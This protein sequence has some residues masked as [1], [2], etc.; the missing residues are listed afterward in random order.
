[1]SE[2]QKASNALAALEEKKASL[3][4]EFK[5]T[6]DLDAEYYEDSDAIENG[7][8]C[9]E[10]DLEW[11]DARDLDYADSMVRYQQLLVRALTILAQGDKKSLHNANKAFETL[12]RDARRIKDDKMADIQK[13]QEVISFMDEIIQACDS[14]RK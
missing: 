9:G 14:H 11:K 1:M 10:I 4:L 2:L 6:Y 8:L 13:A 3:L 7:L 12:V 5:D